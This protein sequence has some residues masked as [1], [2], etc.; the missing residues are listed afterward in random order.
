MGD[1][2]QFSIGSRHDCKSLWPEKMGA[3]FGSENDQVKMA[4]AWGQLPLGYNFSRPRGETGRAPTL[5]NVKNSAP[6]FLC[7]PVQV[8]AL[9]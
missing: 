5:G 7:F 6:T 9:K 2:V 4:L 3:G 1:S 8:T